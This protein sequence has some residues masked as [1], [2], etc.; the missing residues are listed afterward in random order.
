MRLN[1]GNSNQIAQG[2]VLFTKL[3]INITELKEI[4]PNKRGFVLAEGEATGHAHRIEATERAE[5]FEYFDFDLQETCMLLKILQD[6]TE[7]K[8]EEHQSLFLNKGTYR[9]SQINEYDPWAK[10][11]EQIKKVRD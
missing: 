8:H 4:K 3:D 2:D 11:G 9:V 10:I 6:D 5:L 7:V 1:N